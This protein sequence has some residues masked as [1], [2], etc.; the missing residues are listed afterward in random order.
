MTLIR[1]GRTLKRC[2][3]SR[4]VS[5]R[6]RVNSELFQTLTR[7]VYLYTQSLRYVLT[8]N[9]R[10]EANSY[11]TLLRPHN[12]RTLLRPNGTLAHATVVIWQTHGELHT[13]YPRSCSSDSSPF[14]HSH[15][16]NSHTPPCPCSCTETASTCR[17]RAS[18]DVQLAAVSTYPL[19]PSV[20]VRSTAASI[21]DPP[22]S[23]SLCTDRCHSS[24]QA[25]V[26]A[27]WDW[28]GPVRS[29]QRTQRNPRPR[30]VR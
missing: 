4:C 26:S 5:R 1:P 19:S 6:N 18:H 21:A 20:W 28:S 3:D 24:T 2:N 16:H 29:L 23:D 10:G 9:K 25:S 17:S 15:G 7:V 30:P 22:A 8:T 11:S 14:H 27:W 12:A 13:A